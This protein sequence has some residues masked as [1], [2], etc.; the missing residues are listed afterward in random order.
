[1]LR[2][3]EEISKYE[4]EFKKW[5]SQVEK[6]LKRYRDEG[7]DA[8]SNAQSRFNI[9][10]SNV[11]ILAPAV[12]GRLPK[13]DVARRHRS[14]RNVGR[15]GDIRRGLLRGLSLS[16]RVDDIVHREPLVAPPELGREIVLHDARDIFAC[17]GGIHCITQQEPAPLR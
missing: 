17:G 16:S 4:R 15:D 11:Q 1:M 5:E 3:L 2:Y 12:F 9:L 10:W 8:R 14:H 6:I 13:P 7:R